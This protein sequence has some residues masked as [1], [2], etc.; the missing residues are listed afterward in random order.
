MNKA[1]C[2]M[3]Q[4][5]SIK[6]PAAVETAASFLKARAGTASGAGLHS[7]LDRVPDRPPQTGDELE[8]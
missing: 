2:P 3:K 1:T 5:V 6:D 8:R 7:F 4:P